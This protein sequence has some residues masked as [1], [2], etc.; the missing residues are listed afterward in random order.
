MTRAKRA[1]FLASPPTGRDK[2]YI[3]TPHREG[4]K[5]ICLLKEGEGG[6]AFVP[7]TG[8]EKSLFPQSKGQGVKIHYGSV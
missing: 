2:K 7:F 4:P 5:Y 8:K 6:N 3:F 1:I